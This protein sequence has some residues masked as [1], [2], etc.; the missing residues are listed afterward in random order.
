LPDKDK[1]WILAN[2]SLTGNMWEPKHGSKPPFQATYQPRLQ[3]PEPGTY[4]EVI[5]RDSIRIVFQALGL[6]RVVKG[7]P[8]QEILY[9]LDILEPGDIWE[10]IKQ[11]KKG[12]EENYVSSISSK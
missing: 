7:I 9:I 11:K 4:Y 3:Q 2:I 1:E 5:Y 12:L 8:G 10:I 6:V